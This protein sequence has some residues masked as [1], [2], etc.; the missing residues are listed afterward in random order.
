MSDNKSKWVLELD[1]VE[2]AHSAAVAKRFHAARRH[3]ELL[4]RTEELQREITEIQS[5][6]LLDRQHV[7]EKSRNVLALRK[8]LDVSDGATKR[9]EAQLAEL[10]RQHAQKHKQEHDAL[11]QLANQ[12]KREIDGWY[13]RATQFQREAEVQRATTIARFTGALADEKRRKENMAM[14]RARLLQEMAQAEASFRLTEVS[15]TELRRKVATTQTELQRARSLHHELSITHQDI[16]L[17]TAVLSRLRIDCQHLQDQV[18]ELEKGT[19]AA[20]EKN[21]MNNH[22][23]EEVTRFADISAAQS[24]YCQINHL[25]ADEHSSRRLIYR[26]FMQLHSNFVRNFF[27]HAMVIEEQNID[28][29]LRTCRSC[30]EMTKSIQLM[31]VETAANGTK[32]RQVAQESVAKERQL[33]MV[34]QKAEKEID[35]AAQQRQELVAKLEV[36][37]TR[38]ASEREKTSQRLS[39]LNTTRDA[40]LNEFFRQ[41]DGETRRAVSQLVAVNAKEKQ[42]QQ[43]QDK[44]DNNNDQDSGDAPAVTVNLVNESAPAFTAAEYVRWCDEIS[45]AAAAEQRVHDLQERLNAADSAAVISS[46]QVAESRS[47]LL[48][49]EHENETRET[50]LR[51]LEKEVDSRRHWLKNRRAEL[52]EK[53]EAEYQDADQ[54]NKSIESQLRASTDAIA[55]LKKTVSDERFRA[56]AL[57]GEIETVETGSAVALLM[58]ELKSIRESNKTRREILQAAN[59]AASNQARSKSDLE[60]S[61]KNFQHQHAVVRNPADLSVGTRYPP[62]AP[63]DQFSYGDLPGNDVRFFAA[64]DARSPDVARVPTHLDFTSAV[65][66]AKNLVNERST[67]YA[68]GFNSPNLNN[69]NNNNNARSP[70]L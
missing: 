11:E 66:Q 17:E 48:H 16:N 8:Q 53:L 9:A 20:E 65:R 45:D 23:S 21:R 64:N 70:S 55:R 62:A 49:L 42:Q 3:A 35:T 46:D 14:D 22:T 67:L 39:S 33:E 7:E 51:A 2:V 68:P 44:N 31:K 43:Q 61:G 37:Q 25:R 54:R 38:H 60:R 4:V 52:E 56:N 34:L 27:R 50:A 36:H 6:V 58:Q 15:I 40:L 13:E 47:L 63:S 24:F 19:E 57:V 26:D 1:R 32:R 5:H 59:R 41:I 10:E 29:Q 28:E 18:L 12:R 69:N 30:Q